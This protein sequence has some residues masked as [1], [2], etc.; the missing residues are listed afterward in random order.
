MP[1]TAGGNRVAPAGDAKLRIMSRRFPR[2][3]PAKLM[4][5]PV[6]FEAS[7]AAQLF[8]QMLGDNLKITRKPIVDAGRNAP[9]VPS[10]LENRVGSRILPEWMDVVDDPTRPSGAVTPCWG[11]ISTTSRASAQRRWSWWKRGR[12]R[13]FLLDAYASA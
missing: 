13:T 8:G 5:G 2:R 12:S 10:D 7:A 9:H 3:P 1:R 4:T 6:L 11:I